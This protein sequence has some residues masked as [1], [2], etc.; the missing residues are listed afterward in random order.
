MFRNLGEVLTACFFREDY[1]RIQSLMQ[2]DGRSEASALRMALGYSYADFGAAVAAHWELPDSLAEAIRPTVGTPPARNTTIAVFSEGLTRVLYRPEPGASAGA[3]LDALIEAHKPTLA[4]SRSQVGRIVSDALTETH[5]VLQ[6]IDGADSAGQMRTLTSAARGVFGAGLKLPET[7]APT[8]L[9]AP[10]LSTR[11]RLL[12][13]LAQTADGASGVAIG[14]VLLQA[15]EVLTRGAPF[16]RALV[17]FL[18]ADRQQLVA[19]TGIGAGAEALLPRF[20][21]P[22]T[23]RGVPLVTITQQRLP[24]YLPTDRALTLSESRWAQDVGVAQFGV[25]PLIVLGKVIGCLYLDRTGDQ[26]APDRATV[27]FVQA[28]A[29]VVVDAIVSRRQ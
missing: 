15:L 3:G 29:D 21:Y 17:C 9:P 14:T 27:R 4:L 2:E 1:R 7:D 6:T 10:D 26:P 11:T 25:F 22:V 18:T 5:A 23:M 24:L 28:V 12:R 8:I 19:R 13:E 16:D 20:A